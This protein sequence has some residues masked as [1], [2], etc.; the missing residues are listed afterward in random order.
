MI[1]DQKILITGA[2]S[3]IGHELAARLHAA[4]HAIVAVGRDAGRLAELADALPGIAVEQCDLG[5]RSDVEALVPRV[6]DAHPDLDLIVNNAGL[7]FE[8]R[9]TDPDFDLDT[10]ETEVAVNFLAPVWL[11]ARALPYLIASGRETRIVNVSSGLAFFPKTSSAVYCAT[12]AALHS[13][14]RSLR[15]QLDG[16]GVAVSE[17]ILPLVDT[18]MTAGRGSGKIS[19]A[20]AVSQILAGLRAGRDEIYVGKARLIPLLSRVAPSLIRNILRRS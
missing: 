12:K 20:A 15:Y 3:G 8:P 17:V 10:V 5:R 4:G 2:T 11:T 9:L 14:S 16:T 1:S 18:P 19:T 7:Q 13:F 6:F